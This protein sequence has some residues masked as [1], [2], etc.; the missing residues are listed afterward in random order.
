MNNNSHKF[1]LDEIAKVGANRCSRVFQSAS[2]ILCVT[3]FISS[4][5]DKI[6]TSIIFYDDDLYSLFKEQLEKEN[7]SFR[8][9]GNTIWY[10]VEDKKVVL[11]THK[12][13]I[14]NRSV[15]YKFYKKTSQEL[16]LSKLNEVDIIAKHYVKN[17]IYHVSVAKK[18]R[19]NASIIF[20]KLLNENKFD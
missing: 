13:A 18:D 4:C 15:K 12:Y 10:K 2:F 6:E 19:N 20:N 7:V 3:V 1:M 9:D 5:S 8:V 11:K 16:F 17:G 14:K